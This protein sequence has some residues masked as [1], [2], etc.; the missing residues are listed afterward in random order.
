MSNEPFTAVQYKKHIK[1]IE[2]KLNKPIVLI[3]RS[4]ESYN[5]GRLINQ[6]INFIV[7]DKQ[8]FMPFLLIDINEYIS[9]KEKFNKCFLPATQ[10]VLLYHLNQKSLNGCGIKDIAKKLEYTEMTIS[11]AIKDMAD[12]KICN[13]IGKKDITVEFDTNRTNFWSSILP[14]LKSPVIKTVYIDFVPHNLKCYASN[15]SALSHYTNISEDNSKMLA[16]A[17]YHYTNE[18]R[19]ATAHQNNLY[20]GNI[21]LEVWSYDPGRI[22]T[23]KDF[24]DPFSLY[25]TLKGNEDERIQMELEN[26]IDKIL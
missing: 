9:R 11:R 26:L 8:I 4:I 21:N 6:G 7:Q 1:V 3:L 15:I 25:L 18:I 2:E 17:K 19:N 10:A 22:T 16:V 24:V 12:K 13:V 20:E 23:A 14:Y 5:R